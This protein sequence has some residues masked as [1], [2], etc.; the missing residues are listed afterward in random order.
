M[1]FALPLCPPDRIEEA[2]QLIH[3]EIEGFATNPR[4]EQFG[5][6]MIAYIRRVYMGG[7][8]GTVGHFEWNFYNRLEEGQFTNN[9]SE[10]YNNR[11]SSRCRT[12]HPGF[13]QFSSVLGK[14]L[15]NTKS[16]LEQLEAG[17]IRETQSRRSYT[18]QKSR[19]QMK[20]LLIRK[21]MSL[22]RYL[23]AQGVLNHKVRSSQKT[24][25]PDVVV[26][27]TGDSHVDQAV[28]G[29]L[30]SV[31][32]EPEEA[33]AG[34]GAG[35]RGSSRGRRRGGGARAR[36]ARGRGVAPLFRTCEGCGAHLRSSYIKT[37]Q[38]KHCHGQPE[39]NNE[40]DP[41]AARLDPDEETGE[42]QIL[43]EIDNFDNLDF[44]L[45]E[46]IGEVEDLEETIRGQ[47]RLTGLPIPNDDEE[48]QTQRANRE[49]R[50]RDNF[51]SS[52]SSP[53]HQRVRRT[54][55]DPP[56]GV[57]VDEFGLPLPSAQDEVGAWAS[58]PRQVLTESSSS[59]RSAHRSQDDLYHIPLGPQLQSRRSGESPSLAGTGKVM[60]RLYIIDNI[61]ALKCTVLKW[62]ALNLHSPEDFEIVFGS[63]IEFST[64]SEAQGIC[65]ILPFIVFLPISPS[66][67]LLA[68]LLPPSNKI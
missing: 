21:Q 45:E 34:T 20:I 22:R 13:Y 16:K 68:L 30:V 7:S 3:D 53:P 61:T 5:N 41:E 32:E 15:E 9:P 55:S 54:S 14:E 8:F 40:D 58:N 59:S 46:V 65:L 31:S 35:G 56:P 27:A 57:P 52:P 1:C 12:S 62:T 60:Y 28:R 67:L 64:T 47:R 29:A 4:T 24:T 49:K 18:L 66:P 63:N 17:N 37:H 19:L 48:D 38:K 23:R 44:N 42:E 33:G 2:L 6:D 39:E 51:P 50:R 11:L 36:G 10:G 26:V 25:S 43:Q